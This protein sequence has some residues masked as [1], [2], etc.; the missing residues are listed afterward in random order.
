VESDALSDYVMSLFV[1]V[2]VVEVDAGLLAIAQYAI[3]T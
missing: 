3:A 2:P 1:S